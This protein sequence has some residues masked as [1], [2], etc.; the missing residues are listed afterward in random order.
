[1][2]IHPV[3]ISTIDRKIDPVSWQTHFL[4]WLKAAFLSARFYKHKREGREDLT[5]M[6]YSTR[7]GASKTKFEYFW[8]IALV[9][10]FM[11]YCAMVESNITILQYKA[12]FLHSEA[13]SGS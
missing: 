12:L 2:L 3:I 11:T 9:F 7:G 1:M 6:K 13:N 10:L 4:L 8:E 5:T